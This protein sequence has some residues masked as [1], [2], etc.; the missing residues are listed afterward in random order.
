MMVLG[1]AR[2]GRTRV[3]NLLRTHKGW[4]EERPNLC[5]KGAD[6][7]E[8][9]IASS[10]SFPKH[11]STGMSRPVLVFTNGLVE[12]VAVTL[13]DFQSKDVMQGCYQLFLRRYSHR[14]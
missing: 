1:P 3:V 8:L 9:M 4:V 6:Q 13:W 10:L 14:L 5:V 11:N 7:K 2:S 12:R